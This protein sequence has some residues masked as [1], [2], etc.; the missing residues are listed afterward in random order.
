MVYAIVTA[1]CLSSLVA[2]VETR[3]APGGGLGLSAVMAL[4]VGFV[5]GL[6]A[7]Q[8]EVLLWFVGLLGF[9]AALIIRGGRRPIPERQE[10][11][12]QG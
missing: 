6:V 3:T 2:G 10:L 4:L 11:N 9:D 5:S 1:G 8:V 7:A 12:A